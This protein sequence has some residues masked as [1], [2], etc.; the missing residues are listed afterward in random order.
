MT[1]FNNKYGPWALITGPTAGIGE[2]F[3]HQLAAK[4]LNLV[5]V[6]RRL[7]EL[8]GLAQQLENRYNIETRCVD[9]DLS[10]ADFMPELTAVTDELTIGLLV[11]NAGFGNTGE[12]L[13]TPLEDEVRLLHV[14]C[15]APLI[16]AH[17]F[18]RRLQQGG[19]G[20]MIFLASTASYI[21]NPYWA[22]Y[23]ASKAYNLFLGNAL[24][25]ELR[26]SGVD[27]LSLCPG[28]TKTSFHIEANLA[29][30]D[31]SRF[32]EMVL[33]D[34]S[35]VARAALTRLGHRTTHIVGLRNQLMIGFSRVLPRRLRSVIAGKLVGGMMA[36]SESKEDEREQSLDTNA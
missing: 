21:P 29:M 30:D 34:P 24:S 25:E 4:G 18:G 15:R 17:H 35:D 26:Q 3:A 19:G 7:P 2:A 6:A 31:L 12:F 22:N 36:S 16:L 1:N 8:Q 10:R 27:V 13:N 9:L 33:M 32:E 5:L 20:G 14:N 23:A 28:G 11:S